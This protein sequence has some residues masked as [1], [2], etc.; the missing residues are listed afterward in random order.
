[1]NLKMQY[2]TKIL[3][4]LRCQLLGIFLFALPVYILANDLPDAVYDINSVSDNESLKSES[5]TKTTKIY[6][7]S[8]TTVSN[9][10]ENVTAE[11]I[12]IPAK[13]KSKSKKNSKKEIKHKVLKSDKKTERVYA[14]RELKVKIKKFPCSKSGAFL[15][16]TYNS[17]LIIPT[18][19]NRILGFSQ[20]SFSKKQILPI[21]IEEFVYE[22]YLAYYSLNYSIRKEFTRP[23]PSKKG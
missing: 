21:D 17:E 9:L 15:S 4:R 6:I 1:M 23:P 19:Q 3:S 13:P 5:V 8:G 11:I 20:D 16:G 22:Y 12:E 2:L 10:D 7:V 18:I 14:Q